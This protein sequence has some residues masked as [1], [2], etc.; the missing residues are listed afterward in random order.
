MTEPPLLRL[1]L[2]AVFVTVPL[3]AAAA[4]SAP[5]ASPDTG[6]P[7]LA[8]EFVRTTLAYSPS[9]A[10]ALGLHE[11][12]DPTSGRT[13]SLDTLLDDFSTAQLARE[14]RYVTAV[15]HRLATVRR[16]R[17][18]PQSQADYDVVANAA[19]FLRYSL[20]DE[21]F[22][23][24]EPQLY[25]EVLGSAIYAPM[26]LEY[27]DRAT[28]AEHLVAR[29]RQIPRFLE[30]AKHNLRATNAVYTKVALE[31]AAGLDGL[32][33]DMGASL[34]RGTPAQAPL[35]LVTKPALDALAGFRVFVRDTL[36][37]RGT[38]DWR[39]GPSRYATKWKYYLAV[40][41]TPDAMLRTAQDSIRATRR[42]MLALARPLHDAWFP[43]HHHTGAPEAVLNAI[44]SETMARIGS[45]H[46][47]RD[48]LFEVSRRDVAL[49]EDAVRDRRILSLDH[50]PNLQVIP[51]PVFAR[52]SFGEAGAVFA[53]LFQPSLA[54]FYW[55]T[56]I[57]SS[58]SEA[59]VESRLREDNDYMTLGL[60]MH[61]GIPGH[62]VQGT[63]ANLVTPEWR[64]I[65]RGVFANTPYVEG[66]AVYG[67]HVMMYE[68]GVNGGSPVKMRLTDLKGNLRMYLNVVLD[69][70]LHT[71]HLSE[72]SALSMMMR[73]GFQERAQAEAKLQRAQLD[74]V[75]LATYMAGLSDW[76][77]FR[78]EA[79]RR[80][81]AAFDLCRFHD[82]VL[83]YG[84]LPVPV[85][86]RLYFAGIRPALPAGMSRCASR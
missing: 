67:E 4:Q 35:A 58:A 50:V 62:L 74:Y 26:S 86:R 41:M 17:L 38:V 75:Q 52:G 36:P 29:V 78:A 85:V 42:E 57:D 77:A 47:H 28:R 46:P 2:A 16:G 45:E 71:R 76:T 33:R 84:A 51:T 34:A 60:T 8:E 12:T 23:E 66:W 54:A 53:P 40:S 63:Y 65:V 5:P 20:D 55:I 27:A 6:F 21:R 80:E 69:I 39:M 49:L 11:W 70:E 81:G 13:V 18:D 37:G 19:A 31:E 7:A 30:I 83:M 79:M 72:D 25:V 61:E 68:A 48:S 59:D 64:R 14:R 73:D 82:T 44:V 32:I 1:A 24:T 15:Q 3:T 22:T 9:I 43:D 10:V 56:P